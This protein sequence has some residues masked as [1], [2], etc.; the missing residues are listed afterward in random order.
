MAIVTTFDKPVAMPVSEAKYIGDMQRV[1]ITL[2]PGDAIKLNSMVSR[3]LPAGVIYYY[4]CMAVESGVAF[5]LS[6]NYIDYLD[7]PPEQEQ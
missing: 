2:K 4:S 6:T 3:R 5:D 7:V 1:V